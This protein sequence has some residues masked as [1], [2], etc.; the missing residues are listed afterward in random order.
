MSEPVGWIHRFKVEDETIGV[1]MESNDRASAERVFR[2]QSR[3]PGVRLDCVAAT[4][5]GERIDVVF[6]DDA[7][8][9]A[10]SGEPV[11]LTRGERAELLAWRAADTED[12]DGPAYAH[13]QEARRLRAANEAASPPAGRAAAEPPR[14]PHGP[15]D[16][17][18]G[19]AQ[20][21]PLDPDDGRLGPNNWTHTRTRCVDDY[22]SGKVVAEVAA[23]EAPDMVAVPDPSRLIAAAIAWRNGESCRCGPNGMPVD[24]TDDCPA[25]KLDNELF[26]ATWNYERA[27]AERAA[28]GPR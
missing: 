11:A 10:P 1:L 6:A 20:L 7:L 8:A 15:F 12:D 22:G 13:F 19:A 28:E 24:H 17:A 23:A 2:Y 9:P 14:K 27:A 5:E 4:I 18:C 3:R 26:D 16:C 21:D 25:N